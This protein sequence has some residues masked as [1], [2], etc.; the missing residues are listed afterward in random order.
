M[1][2]IDFSMKPCVWPL[3]TTF[4]S[5][6]VIISGNISCS[7][8]TQMNLSDNFPSIDGSEV[9]F[10]MKHCVW[11]L[12]TTFWSRVVII[13]RNISYS[14]ITQM[15]LSC[16]FPSIDGSEVHFSIKYYF[17]PYLTRCWSS[18]VTWSDQWKPFHWIRR[19]G[20]N[21]TRSYEVINNVW[22]V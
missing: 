4:W 1:I 3:L 21:Y 18:L 19:I 12:L 17:W 14:K 9:H 10:P 5:R 16:N 15:N 11:P 20:I 22:N 6:V 7:K 8:I 13:R 2:K